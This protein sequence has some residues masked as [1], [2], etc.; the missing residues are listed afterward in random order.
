MD[1]KHPK[2]VRTIKAQS[3]S[4]IFEA[5]KYYFIFDCSV[6]SERAG[7]C[8]IGFVAPKTVQFDSD[9]TLLIVFECFRNTGVVPGCLNGELRFSQSSVFV[10][11]YTD[12]KTNVLNF[13]FFLAVPGNQRISPEM[14]VFRELSNELSPKKI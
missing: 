5:K 14:S 13:S 3:Y 2:T 12:K 11:K 9:V 10:E 7:K 1:Q 4:T 8:E 6:M